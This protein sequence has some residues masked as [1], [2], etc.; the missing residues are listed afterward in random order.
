MRLYSFSR[1][2][3]RRMHCRR[4]LTVPQRKQHAP[5]CAVRTDAAAEALFAVCTAFGHI[6]ECNKP[7]KKK[8]VAKTS[9][10]R[11]SIARFRSRCA[12]LP[13][14]WPP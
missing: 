1:L 8:L 7:I 6:I 12:R 5:A 11:S 2:T 13:Y 9:F 4:L 3:D 10:F 14:S